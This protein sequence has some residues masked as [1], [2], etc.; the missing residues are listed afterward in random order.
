MNERDKLLPCPFCGS[1]PR[2]L[3]YKAGFW[4]ERVICDSCEFHLPPE[5]WNLRARAAR[6]EQA[7]EPV[8]WRQRYID[9][10][11]G[12]SIWSHCD[13]HSRRLLAGRADYEVQPLYTHPQTSTPADQ[14]TETACMGEPMLNYGQCFCRIC[15]FTGQSTDHASSGCTGIPAADPKGVFAPAEPVIDGYPLCQGIPPAD[16]VECDCPALQFCKRNGGCVKLGDAPADH[17]AADATVREEGS[18]LKTAASAVGV[19][20]LDALVARLHK[21][22]AQTMN[23]TGDDSMALK[24][25]QAITDLRADKAHAIKVA[26][27]EQNWRNDDL[28]TIAR[29][30][31][32]ITELQAQQHK[33]EDEVGDMVRFHTECIVRLEADNA[34]AR[35]LRKAVRACG[36]KY[37]EL[38]SDIDALLAKQGG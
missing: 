7:G 2:R 21:A 12:P 1:D 8:A 32:N 27:Q 23:A 6:Q 34:K 18:G 31:G 33:R 15:G 24:A 20:D 37:G 22:H 28:E 11:E 38:Q 25:A 3:E 10:E 13:E 29:L 5:T 9:P 36:V 30:N 19:T 4:T 26:E 35:E 17:T 16:E 14:S